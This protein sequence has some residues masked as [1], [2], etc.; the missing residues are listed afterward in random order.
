MNIFDSYTGISINNNGT[1][2]IYQ[3]IR[4]YHG[5]SITWDLD[6]EGEYI[7]DQEVTFSWEFSGN[8]DP[9]DYTLT[10]VED[11]ISVNM[12][13]QQMYIDFDFSN[14]HSNPVHNLK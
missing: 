3:D 4:S 5:T 8:E 13:L 12:K 14:F 1:S 9:Y 11:D 10:I 7:D 2:S 6:L